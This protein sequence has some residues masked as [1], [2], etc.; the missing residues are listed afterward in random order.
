MSQ[1]NF[2]NKNMDNNLNK[3]VDQNDKKN[4]SKKDHFTRNLVIFLIIF[5]LICVGITVFLIIKNNNVKDSKNDVNIAKTEVKNNITSDGLGLSSRYE[6]YK[7]NPIKISKVYIKKPN[8]NSEYREFGCNY[9]QIDGLANEEIESKI[10]NKIK[11]EITSWYDSTKKQEI[12]TNCTANFGNVI[13]IISTKYQD[14]KMEHKTFNINL[15]NGEEIKFNDLFTNTAPMKNILNKSVSDSLILDLTEGYQEEL[16]EVTDNPEMSEYIR[17]DITPEREEM[18]KNV[19]STVFKYLAFYNNGGEFVFSFSPRCAYIYKDDDVIKIPMYSYYNNI[20]IYNRYKNN[21]NI[22]D[23]QYEKKLDPIYNENI[24][25][26]TSTNDINVERDILLTEAVNVDYFNLYKIDENNL[27]YIR[28][29]NN[30]FSD[31]TE[32]LWNAI[33]IAKTKIEKYKNNDN[34]KAKF[35]CMLINIDED[36][37]MEI[38]EYTTNGNKTEFYNNIINYFQRGGFEFYVDPAEEYGKKLFNNQKVEYKSNSSYKN[39]DLN[40]KYDKSSKKWKNESEKTEQKD[41]SN[42]NDNNVNKE[43]NTEI[44]TTSNNKVIVIDPG[45]QTKG[46]SAKEPIGPGASETKA[47]VTGGATGVATGQT[48]YNLNLVVSLKLKKELESKGYKVIMTRTTNDI[49]ISNSERAKIA[50]NANAAAF[51]RIHANSAESSA[52]KGVL[53]MCQ[54][55]NN[56][57]NG[58]LADTSYKLSKSVLDGIVKTTGA[59]NKGVTRTDDM[60]GINWCTVPTTIVEMGF[61][62]NTEE[63]KLLASDEY[64]NKIVAGIVNGLDQFLN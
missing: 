26:F 46:N 62:S 22:Y 11:D 48:E 25:V 20:A 29:A 42:N 49:D 31:D 35:I 17:E 27:A 41:N 37:S 52:A 38:N 59:Q 23:G 21:S 2:E 19:E 24:Y 63:D 14:D 39:A 16:D 47:K 33:E 15:N 6:T 60:S 61:L 50:N 7:E 13:S 8:D 43:N 1:E 30:Y 9:I 55:Q 4:N 36:L 64:Q 34:N 12:I 3:N 56:K 44:T 10:N 45:H 54:T 51:I 40:Y 57:F 5:A 18:I 58:N 32:K 28:I 53:T